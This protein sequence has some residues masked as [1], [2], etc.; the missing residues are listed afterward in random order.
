MRHGHG[1]SKQ[2]VIADKYVACTQPCSP[3]GRPA[4]CS[5]VGKYRYPLLQMHK[6]LEIR[7]TCSR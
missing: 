1:G 5:D 4:P 6:L 7:A 3:A 2:M